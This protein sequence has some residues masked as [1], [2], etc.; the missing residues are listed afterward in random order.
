MIL[1]LKKNLNFFNFFSSEI[2][3]KNRKFQKLLQILLTPKIWH[4]ETLADGIFFEF[5]NKDYRKNYLKKI[6]EISQ[7][8]FEKCEKS[9]TNDINNN[10]NF[11]NIYYP[12]GGSMYMSD[13][14]AMSNSVENRS[15]LMDH[16]LFE[17]MLSV[18]DS[19]KKQK[20]PKKYS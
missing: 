6:G 9:L 2:I 15:P 5:F 7:K 10:V 20:R 12:L 19:F 17:L 14:S 13:M 8:I 4:A 16:N 3:L 1:L 18:S 11:L